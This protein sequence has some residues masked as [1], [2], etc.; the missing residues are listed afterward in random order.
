MQKKMVKIGTRI[1]AEDDA[2]MERIAERNGL[3]GKLFTI[4]S[5]LIRDIKVA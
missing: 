5:D 2:R 1:T 4:I 3:L